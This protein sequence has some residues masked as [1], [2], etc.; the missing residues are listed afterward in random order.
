MKHI[1]LSFGLMCS[2]A[3]MAAIPVD[4]SCENPMP[5]TKDFQETISAAG[6]YWFSAYTYDLPLGGFFVADD[7][8]NTENPIAWV[9]F[10][11]TTGVYDDALLSDIVT[12]AS[13]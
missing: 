2:A 9:D 13:G 10:S 6:E 3:V 12:S 4:N 5:V 8:N 1:L 11:C 7:A